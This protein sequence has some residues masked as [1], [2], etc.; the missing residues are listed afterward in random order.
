M[1][2]CWKCKVHVVPSGRRLCELCRKPRRRYGI[3]KKIGRRNI[4]E[5]MRSRSKMRYIKEEKFEDS[6]GNPLNIVVTEE[7]KRVE[8][9]G[10]IGDLLK[11]L[12]N[13]Y[14][15]DP[16]SR[17][18]L[19]EPENRLYNK[20]LNVLEAKPNG[21]NYFE[22]EDTEFEILDR[23]CMGSIL[24]LSQPF[25]KHVPQVADL[26]KNAMGKDEYKKMFSKEDES[27]DQEIKRTVKKSKKSKK[28]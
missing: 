16:Q 27:N 18:T 21:N 5:R 12:L 8:K 4:V 20:C 7:G 22:F 2:L 24:L 13:T 25:P 28:S 14:N 9:E 19:T 1:E 23:V 26:F 6:K 17:R 15:P 10:S 3:S 11:F